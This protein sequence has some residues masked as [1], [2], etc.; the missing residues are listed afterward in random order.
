MN[1]E[2]VQARLKYKVKDFMVEEIGEKFEGKIS[3]EFI[4]PLINC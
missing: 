4:S 1:D 2:L 3:N